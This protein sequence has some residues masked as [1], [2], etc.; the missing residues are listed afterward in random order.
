MSNDNQHQYHR[1]QNKAQ[2]KKPKTAVCK[3]CGKPIVKIAGLWT[4]GYENGNDSHRA[5]V[6]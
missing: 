3:V 4:H 1:D 5:R 2:S 6:K